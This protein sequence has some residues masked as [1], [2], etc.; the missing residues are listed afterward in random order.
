M[1]QASEAELIW[2]I[3][4]TISRTSAGVRRDFASANEQSRKF[5]EHSLTMALMKRLERYE[6]LSDAPLPEGSDLFSRAAYGSSD[7]PILGD[8]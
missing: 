4:Y 7:Q 2:M 8:G 5:A 3:R 6:V 1:R